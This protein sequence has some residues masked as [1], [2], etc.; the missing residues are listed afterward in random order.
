MTTTAMI[1]SKFQFQFG[2]VKFLTFPSKT[3]EL[4]AFEEKN[5]RFIQAHGIAL[6]AA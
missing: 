4:N 3:F 6:F 5:V 1:M 2:D